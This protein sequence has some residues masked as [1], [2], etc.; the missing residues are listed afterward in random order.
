MGR[1]HVPSMC[2]RC[3]LLRQQ[4]GEHESVPQNCTHGVLSLS[5]E[6]IRHVPRLCLTL[7]LRTK[8]YDAARA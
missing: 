2:R 7:K 1:E 3:V 5:Y 8:K 4:K 6:V